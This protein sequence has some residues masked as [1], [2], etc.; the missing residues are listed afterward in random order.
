MRLQPTTF[1]PKVHVSYTESNEPNEEDDEPS[2]PITSNAPTV[3]SSFPSFTVSAATSIT[4]EDEYYAHA[5]SN[6]QRRHD[7]REQLKAIFRALITIVLLGV[8][9]LG[10]LAFPSFETLMGVMG[11]GMSIITCILIP[12]A[13]GA[14]IWGWRWYSLLLFGLSAVVCAIGV[15]CAFLNNGDIA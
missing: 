7:R 10:A 15:V 4:L 1:V 2:S 5:L 3:L 11:G 9:V 6:A 13:A 8:F 12:I 14:S